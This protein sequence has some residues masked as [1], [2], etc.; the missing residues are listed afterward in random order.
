MIDVTGI[1]KAAFAKAVYRLSVP[2]G[3]G[4]LHAKTGPL[5]DESANSIANQPTFH[6]N[7]V[8]GRA[9][10]MTLQEQDG[11][12]LA[13]DSWYDHTDRDY[14]ELLSEF[15][16]SRESRP[17]HS[18]SCECNECRPDKPNRAACWEKANAA[19]GN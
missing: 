2:R 14:E 4:I 11:K 8:E 3:F 18:E 12:L 6:M 19:P 9:C 7:Y 16:F 1:D 10:K 5:D 13:S 15:G 17:A